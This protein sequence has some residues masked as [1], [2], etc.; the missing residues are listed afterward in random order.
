[1]EIKKTLYSKFIPDLLPLSGKSPVERLKEIPFASPS[2]TV[3][4][5]REICLKYMKL[6]ISFPWKL[7]RDWNYIIE[8]RQKEVAL[9]KGKLYGG[10]PYVT[11]G[12]GNL[13]RVCEF[14]DEATKTIDIDGIG[15]D[16]KIFGNACSGATSCAWARVIGS[17]KRFG[18]TRHMT[19][20][21][22]FLTVGPYTYSE[23]LEQF[24]KPEIDKDWGDKKEYTP[25]H[26]CE[27]NGADVM[28]ESYAQVL[29]ADG[30][31]DP[32]HVRMVSTMPHI[33]RDENGKISGSESYLTTLE[34]Y[35]SWNDRI[36]DNGDLISVEGGYNHRYTFD[37]LFESGYIPF[38][39]AEFHG[40][41]PILEAALSCSLKKDDCSLT[42]LAEAVIESNFA[43]SDVFI[44]LTEDR[45][46][47]FRHVIRND[48]FIIRKMILGDEAVNKLAQAMSAA[49]KI[50]IECQL[51]HGEKLTAY[52][53]ILTQ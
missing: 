26:I 37:M 17:V 4:E 38:T 50:K 12:S 51:Y 35:A 19:Q 18:Y 28:F 25:K 44:T 2:M 33:V 13:Y 42:E 10:L 27:E 11:K 39:F 22:G 47:F 48:D 16:P 34:Q 45:A 31:V 40:K 46:E 30:I 1:M 8:R 6:Q 41:A 49:C 32:G 3:G 29:P 24:I 43:I 15:Y 9:V 23:E 14:Y 7:T 20:K 36:L 52:E 21:C 53:G 5:L